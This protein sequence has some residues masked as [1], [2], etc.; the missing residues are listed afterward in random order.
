MEQMQTTSFTSKYLDGHSGWLASCSNSLPIIKSQNSHR[1][2]PIVDVLSPRACG[3]FRAIQITLAKCVS[4][5]LT[6]LVDKKMEFWEVKLSK[7]D[8]RGLLSGFE[9]NGFLLT[10][11]KGP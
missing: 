10:T 1:I 9:L 3:Q 4:K 5:K 11:Y 7:A 6:F 8:N 2:R